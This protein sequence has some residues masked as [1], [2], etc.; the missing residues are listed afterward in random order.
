MSRSMTAYA[1]EQLDAEWGSATWELRSLNHRYLDPSIRLPEEWR[2]LETAVREKLAQK[3]KR[4]KV[5]CTLR[6]RASA[7]SAGELTLD[8]ELAMHLVQAG[9]ALTKLM[10]TEDPGT[11][12]GLS[13]GEVLRWPGVIEPE[14]LDTDTLGKELLTLLDQALNEL[15]AGREREGEKLK[16]LLLER[17]G[18]VEG[19]VSIIKPSVPAIIDAQRDRLRS[20]LAELGAEAD[21]GRIEQEVVIYAQKID[22]TEELDRLETHVAEVRRVL[23]DPG[24]IG[25]RLDFIMQELNR[26]AN[27]LGSKSVDTSTT[28]ASVDLKVAIEQM[29]EQIQNLE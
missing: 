24:P 15:V 16:A 21:S 4:G 14:L 12:G 19:V 18:L 10:R 13:V 2:S 17:C 20:R 8:M 9:S 11:R 3:L 22:V 25:R 26:E 6:F 1:R 29:R 5:E 23:D 7:A 27:T 28:N